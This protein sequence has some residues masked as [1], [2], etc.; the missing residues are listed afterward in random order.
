MY[1]KDELE[2]QVDFLK[3]QLSSI[4]EIE[5]DIDYRNNEELLKESI[6]T[7]KHALRNV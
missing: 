6:D 2:A 4:V 3:D 5:E 1:T 7:A